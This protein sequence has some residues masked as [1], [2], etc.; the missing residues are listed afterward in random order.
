ME[1]LEMHRP[2][3]DDGKS[4]EQTAC[5]LEIRHFI[6]GMIN[7]PVQTA[8]LA[9]RL[10]TAKIRRAPPPPLIDLLPEMKLLPT[11]EAQ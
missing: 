10:S 4:S 3:L 2:A 5:G 8:I 7:L 11:T 9:L 6:E 1:L